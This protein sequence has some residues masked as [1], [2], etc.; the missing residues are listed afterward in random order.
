MQP[1][2]YAQHDMM[3]NDVDVHVRVAMH[4]LQ[5]VKEVIAAARQASVRSNDIQS[6]Q[7]T[8][9][10]AISPNINSEGVVQSDTSLNKMA[11]ALGVPKS[12]FKLQMQVAVKSCQT[13][14][15]AMNDSTFLQTY[16]RSGRTRFTVDFIK[17]L[18]HWLLNDCNNVIASP[19]KNDT[20]LVYDPDTKKKERKQKYFY[21]FSICEVHNEMIDEKGGFDGARDEEG[22]VILSDTSLRMLLPKQLWQLTNSQKQMCGCKICIVGRSRTTTLNA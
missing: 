12:T 1:V 14:V 20:V 18:H 17:R 3:L 9:Y 10:T 5:Q 7:R 8:V 21:R 22:K 4:T 15:N 16:R 13:I 19:N 11:A 2:T 6:F